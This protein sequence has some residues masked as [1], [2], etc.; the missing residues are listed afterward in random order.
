MYWW[1]P[2]SGPCFKCLTCNNNSFKS[3]YFWRD[4]QRPLGPTAAPSPC[5]PER[6]MDCNVNDSPFLCSAQPVQL[7]VA[8]LHNWTWSPCWAMPLS[9]PRSGIGLTWGLLSHKWGCL[10]S[11]PEPVSHL[12]ILS[13]INKHFVKGLFLFCT[14]ASPGVTITEVRMYCPWERLNEEFRDLRKW[15]ILNRVH[16][17]GWVA[18]FTQ[19]FQYVCTGMRC[20]R[21]LSNM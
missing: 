16:G 21:L 5:S 15:E 20:P 4:L 19:G 10:L 6:V 1:S 14:V 12:H 7:D 11:F 17:L 13:F 18:A 2:D 9:P 3:H 8:T